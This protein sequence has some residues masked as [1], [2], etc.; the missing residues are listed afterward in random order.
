MIRKK[1][2]IAG[3]DK[4]IRGKTAKKKEKDKEEE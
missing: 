1:G 2:K 4:R 3:E